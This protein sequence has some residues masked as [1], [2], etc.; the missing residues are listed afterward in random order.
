M[1]ALPLLAFFSFGSI[2][3]GIAHVS[4]VMMRAVAALPRDSVVFAHPETARLLGFFTGRSPYSNERWE[5]A[6]CGL[7][8]SPLCEEAK[9]R[10]R[11]TFEIYYSSSPGAVAAFAASSGVTH[12][13]A[14][15]EFYLPDYLEGR[16]GHRYRFIG[17]SHKRGPPVARP[18][19]LARKQSE[20]GIWRLSAGSNA[21]EGPKK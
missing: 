20:A 13:L 16:L 7:I 10:H 6:L 1:T 14:E 21:A 9:D 2:S 12:F 4:P 15:E 8:Q 5:T 18:P 11:K 3:S 17:R 19:G